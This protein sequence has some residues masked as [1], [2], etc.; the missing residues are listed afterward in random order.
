V[1]TQRLS[2]AAR[3]GSQQVTIT[4]NS[5]LR[6]AP[7]QLR[8]HTGTVQ[9]TLKDSGAYPHNIVVTALHVTSPSVTGGP[10][11]SEVSVIVTFRHAGTY[12]FRC[13]YQASAGMV[14]TFVVS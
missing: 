7:M 9:I 10:G 1:T 8:Q 11:S 5:L 6:F 4:G 12:A 2:Q 3:L 13:Q 14:G